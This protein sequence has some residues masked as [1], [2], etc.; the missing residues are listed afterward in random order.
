M[1]IL[2]S[3]NVGPVVT[4]KPSKTS[5]G[6]ALASGTVTPVAGQ[7]V[8]WTLVQDKAKASTRN[9]EAL[10]IRIDGDVISTT[11]AA[12]T[13]RTMAAVWSAVTKANI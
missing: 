9:P 8:R 7:E 3:L 12:T 13:F 2:D 1:S 4:A 5:K 11:K 10:F 6:K